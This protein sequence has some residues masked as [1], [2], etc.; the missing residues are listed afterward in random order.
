MIEVCRRGLYGL[1]QTPLFCLGMALNSPC[2]RSLPQYTVLALE[3]ACERP[4]WV[5]WF[6]G[7]TKGL[8]E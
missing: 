2:W 4:I 5:P 3:R 7:D 1:T 6:S 8:L